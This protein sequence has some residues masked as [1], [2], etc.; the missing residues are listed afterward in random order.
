MEP[1]IEEID[2]PIDSPISQTTSC[3]HYMF[4]ESNDIAVCNK[5]CG[6]GCMAS[7]NLFKIENG[8]IIDL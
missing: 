3:E 5:G 8:K 1:I 7:A 2:L 4:W 6:H